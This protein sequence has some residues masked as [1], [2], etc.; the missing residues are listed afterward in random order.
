MFSTEINPVFRYQLL[1]IIIIF[2]FSYKL[3][4]IVFVVTTVCN[5]PYTIQFYQNN[6]FCT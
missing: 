6:L 5:K 4:V 1:I 3:H 2:F